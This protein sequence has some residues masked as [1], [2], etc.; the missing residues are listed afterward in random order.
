M[1]VAAFLTLLG[2][3]A[4]KKKRLQPSHSRDVIEMLM[5]QYAPARN[6]LANRFR[7]RRYRRGSEEMLRS[8]H[9]SKNNWPV[10]VILLHF[11]MKL[12]RNF[13]EGLWDSGLQRLIHMNGLPKHLNN[14]K[15]SQ[16]LVR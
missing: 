3:D 12:F 16:F 7:F 9:R 1:T 13:F 15:A 11:W 6:V 5:E 10:L 2:T 14:F 8:I 4:Y